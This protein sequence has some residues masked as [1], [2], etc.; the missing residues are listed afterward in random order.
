MADEQQPAT[1]GQQPAASSQQEQPGPVPYER[2][3]EV[4]ETAKQLQTRLAKFEAD[5][6]AQQ[7][8]LLKEQQNYQKLFEEREAELK[9]ERTNNLKMKVALAKGLPASLID[10]LRGEDEE[11]LAKDADALL[12]LI[13]PA[14]PEAPKAPGVPPS[15]GGKPARLDM[16]A[17]TP[18]EIRQHKEALYKQA[19]S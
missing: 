7:E 9:A 5:Q 18:A 11:S 12:A 6:K 4:N 3:K 1:N 15:R 16:S 14:E 13:K 8:K 10:R 2:F 17:M 19:Q